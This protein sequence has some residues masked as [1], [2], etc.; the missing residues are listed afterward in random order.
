MLIFVMTY[1]D[2][3]DFSHFILRMLKVYVYVRSRYIVSSQIS[4]L[5]HHIQWM[6][7][8]EH[9]WNHE[10]MLWNNYFNTWRMQPDLI[11]VAHSVTPEHHHCGKDHTKLMH[12]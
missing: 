3:V 11:F 5:R 7:T 10:I 9:I 8:L 1:Q 4:Q 12:A 2:M 6:G